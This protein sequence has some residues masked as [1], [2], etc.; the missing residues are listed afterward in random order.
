MILRNILQKSHNRLFSSIRIFGIKTENKLPLVSRFFY[1]SYN[2]QRIHIHKLGIQKDIIIVAV[3]LFNQADKGIFNLFFFVVDF[4]I[5][6]DI[7]TFLCNSI[8]DIGCKSFQLQG[9]NLALQHFKRRIIKTKQL[10]KR[11]KW[12]IIIF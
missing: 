6:N 7:F 3:Q 8:M 10:H 11:T 2:F 9:I 5:K 4:M 1:L 12:R